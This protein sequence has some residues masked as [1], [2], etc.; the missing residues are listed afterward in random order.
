MVL[1]VVNYKKNRSL[2]VTY[3][4]M[5]VECIKSLKLDVLYVVCCDVN[6]FLVFLYFVITY[7]LSN[8]YFIFFTSKYFKIYIKKIYNI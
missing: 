6:L 2:C 7:Y 1:K 4:K 3:Q 8:V 5:K